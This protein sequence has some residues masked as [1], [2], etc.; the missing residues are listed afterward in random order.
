MR[1][2]QELRGQTVVVHA[3]ACVYRGTVVELGE[4]ALVL[5]GASGYR[6]IP[7]VAVQRIERARSGGSGARGP[8]P[9]GWSGGGPEER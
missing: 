7:W 2:W 4:D 5:R 1:R 3:L 9:R 8:L 6:E